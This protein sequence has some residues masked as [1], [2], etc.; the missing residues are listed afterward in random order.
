MSERIT[1]FSK[2]FVNLL[3][4]YGYQT[5]AALYENEDRFFW[6]ESVSEMKDEDIAIFIIKD[7]VK[8]ENI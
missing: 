4:Q 7:E 1:S 3:K 2:D 5:C 8:D 6:I